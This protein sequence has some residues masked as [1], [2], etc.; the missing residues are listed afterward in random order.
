NVV[1]IGEVKTASSPPS[2]R[3]LLTQKSSKLVDILKVLLCYSNNFM[4]ERIGD[5]LGGPESVRRQLIALLGIPPDTLKISS[6][7]GLGVNRMT[8]QDMMKIF[9]SL[10][11]ELQKNGLTPSDVMP[12]A[13]IDP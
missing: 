10:R 12:V 7:S 3:L 11:D 8:P 6:L 4:A 9:R 2:T 1:V 5:T 13:G